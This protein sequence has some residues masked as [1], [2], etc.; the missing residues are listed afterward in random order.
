[1]CHPY[2]VFA[3]V[4]L[5]LQ[6]F[7]LTTFSWCNGSAIAFQPNGSEF[8]S[9]RGQFFFDVLEKIVT[10]EMKLSKMIFHYINNDCV[11]SLFCKKFTRNLA[12][13]F[14][15]HNWQISLH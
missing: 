10:K 13:V 1:M 4:R 8:K 14:Y 9:A 3:I 2:K 7:S 15:N 11:I 6:P 5:D 12:L